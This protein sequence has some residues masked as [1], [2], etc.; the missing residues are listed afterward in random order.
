MP[1]PDCNVRVVDVGIEKDMT[2]VCLLN[3]DSLGTT[4]A[5]RVEYGAIELHST[6]ANVNQVLGMW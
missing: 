6:S 3:H 1:A 2:G 4:I 5:F